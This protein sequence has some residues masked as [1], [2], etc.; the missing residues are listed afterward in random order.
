MPMLLP[1][2][3]RLCSHVECRAFEQER[4]VRS[5]L[6][7]WQSSGNEVRCGLA[8]GLYVGWSLPLG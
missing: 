7:R 6:L 5:V 2:R 1:P 3:G 4:I 8:V